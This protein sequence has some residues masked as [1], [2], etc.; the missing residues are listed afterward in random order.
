MTLGVALLLA[1]ASV[2]ALDVGFLL[3]QQAV[4]GAP[5]L[6][7]R[8]PREAARALAGARVWVT[9]FVVGLG[10]WGLYLAAVSRAPICSF[11]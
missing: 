9:G 10:G 1:L 7:L 6:A 11:K 8:R 5:R 3:Q 4:A 2:L